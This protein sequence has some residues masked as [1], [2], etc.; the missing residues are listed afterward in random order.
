MAGL[1]ADE[2]P[3]R[4]QGSGGVPAGIESTASV[5]FP[6]VITGGN[7]TLQFKNASAAG[8]TTVTVASGTYSSMTSLLAALNTVVAPTK[9][10]TVVADATGTLVVL[11]STVLGV[12]SYIN[13]GAGGTINATLH[14]PTA[15]FTMPTAAAIVNGPNAG[16][17]LLPVGGPLNVSPANVLAVLGAAPSTADIV[18][19]IAPQLVET[20]EVIQ[21]FQVGN[22]SQYLSP[23][24]N[25]DSRL[26][27]PLVNGA[28]ITVVQNDGVTLYTA[29]LPSITTAI[30]NV[31][32]TGD[33]TITGT[34]LGNSEFFYAT[35]VRV[36]AGTSKPGLQPAYVRLGQKL[37]QSTLS[38]GTQ[39]VVS[40]TSIVIPAS[41]LTYSPPGNPFP[42]VAPAAGVA[43]GVVGSIVEVEFTTLSATVSGTT[44]SIASA[45]PG[46]SFINSTNTL[47][48][49]VTVTMT[50]LAGVSAKSVGESIIV[51]GASAPGNNGS[52]VIQS[53]VSPSSVTFY[54]SNAVA[55]DANNAHIY[56]SIPGGTSYVVT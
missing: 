36:T 34:D 20:T 41:L 24:F 40:P 27:P 38:G 14:F 3:A 31:P 43:L 16:A 21:S 45:V 32:N 50:G 48:K 33:I 56:W 12:G 47:S 4:Y 1:D 26:M 15:S 49:Q 35:T 30:H 44:A 8:F 5:T 17:A 10:A 7:D 19:F 23:F 11:Q 9:L 28:A 42:P 18:Q 46:P 2:D 51:M 22:M 39:G 25:P 54:N 53:V 52:F 13:I 37:I 55:P 29:P 6:V